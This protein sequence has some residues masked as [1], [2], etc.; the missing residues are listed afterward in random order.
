[1]GKRSIGIAKDISTNVINKSYEENGTFLTIRHNSVLVLDSNTLD[2]SARALKVCSGFYIELGRKL[3]DFI[4]ILKDAKIP[5]IF[6]HVMKA[7][8]YVHYNIVRMATGKVDDVI[9][10]TIICKDGIIEK[11]SCKK[12][13]MREKSFK[14]YERLGAIWLAGSFDY[15]VNIETN[16]NNAKANVL[17]IMG[18]TLNV[19]SDVTLRGLAGSVYGDKSKAMLHSAP[20][21]YNIAQYNKYKIDKDDKE[22]ITGEY[23]DYSNNEIKRSIDNITHDGVVV[24]PDGIDVN[25]VVMWTVYNTVKIHIR[26]ETS[27][28]K[29]KFTYILNE[30][31]RK[32]ELVM[33]S[34]V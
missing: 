15:T 6:Q 23:N 19:S 11:L 1:M 29:Y 16:K 21:L 22:N 4:G 18:K 32:Y 10:G 17:A 30:S 8:G 2:K 5:V 7:N 31:T 33:I 34:L 3:N 14:T 20:M 13:Y 28:V 25:G 12:D 26:F 9:L 24:P 27:K